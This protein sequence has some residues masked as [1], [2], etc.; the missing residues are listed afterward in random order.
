M[1][2]VSNLLNFMHRTMAND[3]QPEADMICRMETFTKSFSLKIIGYSLIK[4]AK[5]HGM[6]VG[7]FDLG[8][9]TWAIT[10]FPYVGHHNEWTA[11]HVSLL[12]E[13]KTVITLEVE[14][15]LFDHV[16]GTYSAVSVNAVKSEGNFLKQGDTII[17]GQF[18]KNQIFEQ[19]NYLNDDC[20]MIKCA[21]KLV[22]PLWVEARKKQVIVPSSDFLQNFHQLWD[23]REGAD[24]VF[25]VGGET[26]S[27]HRTVLAARSPVF[28]AEF[29]GPMKESKTGCVKIKDIEPKVF[30]LMLQ[31]VYTDIIPLNKE[32]SFEMTQHLLV[33]ADRYGLER[34]KLICKEKL[35]NSIDV[36]NASDILVFSDKHNCDQLKV[37]CL[38]FIV[39]G[40]NLKAVM[41]TDGF[42]HL[43][44]TCPFVLRDL[45]ERR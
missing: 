28:K 4:K 44:E 26:I 36:E 38:D 41:A 43:I 24:V 39:S 30:T 11:L 14:C 1:F 16:I 23:S 12:T 37:I 19:S 8:G 35:S 27:A 18:I 31:F 34:L 9:H 22:K 20:F 17:Q 7:T 42:K 33:A 25:Q 45:L 13:T 21:V 29:F 3:E 40:D 10:F 6:M 15:S 32:I 2:F 5:P